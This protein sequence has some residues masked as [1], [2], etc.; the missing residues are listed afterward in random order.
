MVIYSR[1]GG[2]DVATVASGVAHKGPRIG[3]MRV[4][5]PACCRASVTNSIN[6]NLSGDATGHRK[7]IL[8]GI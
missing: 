7:A 5:T 8:P 2:S 4:A 6:N 3:C 1:F